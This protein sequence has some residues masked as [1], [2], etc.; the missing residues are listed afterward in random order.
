[1]STFHARMPEA[2]A[3][4]MTRRNR[5]Q[6]IGNYGI[7]PLT[8]AERAEIDPEPGSWW[9]LVAETRQSWRFAKTGAIEQFRYATHEIRGDSL[10]IPF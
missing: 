1:M 10:E 8:K 5:G 7:R 2:K 4:K 3:A 6:F 9:R